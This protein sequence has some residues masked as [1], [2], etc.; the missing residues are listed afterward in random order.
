MSD[1]ETALNWLTQGKKV[2]RKHWCKSYF[3]KLRTNC[4]CEMNSSNKFSFKLSSFYADDWELFNEVC[5]YK[6]QLIETIDKLINICSK[7]EHPCFLQNEKS[8]NKPI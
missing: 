6:K 2:R 1:F 4:I 3:I 8:F 5:V 7:C